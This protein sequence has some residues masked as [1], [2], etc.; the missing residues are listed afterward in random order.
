MPIEK[1]RHGVGRVV[2]Y[3]DGVLAAG[4]ERADGEA[5]PVG[6][7]LEGGS[8]ERAAF[9]LAEDEQ[10]IVLCAGND[11]VLQAIA[12]DVAGADLIRALA[13]GK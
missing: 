6:R 8:A 4:I 13:A 11:D 9:Q 7:D 2:R 5:G 12:K 10:L 3:D 1:N